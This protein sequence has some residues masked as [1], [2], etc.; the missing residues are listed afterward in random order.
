MLRRLFESYETEAFRCIDAGLVLPGHDYV[1]KC[2][3][4]F[5][6]LD[7]RGAVSVT[8]RAKVIERI[9][10]MACRVARAYVE[11]REQLGHP[12]LKQTEEAAG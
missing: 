6:L 9:R 4:A 2:S 5:N 8:E 1:L 10:R 3:H 12:L 11:H 7:A